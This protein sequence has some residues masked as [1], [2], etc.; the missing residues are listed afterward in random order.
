MWR[1]F[2][3]KGFALCDWMHLSAS[4]MVLEMERLSP[5]GAADSEVSHSGWWFAA[6]LSFLDV[7]LVFLWF[8]T[9]RK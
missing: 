1:Y 2:D 9:K 7:E 4:G 5:P 8:S 3:R 6:L